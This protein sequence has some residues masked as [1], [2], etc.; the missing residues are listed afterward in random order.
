[1]VPRKKIRRILILSCLAGGNLNL[2]SLGPHSHLH[3]PGTWE[4]C[5]Q[6]CIALAVPL[7]LNGI[8]NAVSRQNLRK[9][10]TPKSL[11]GSLPK[12]YA[13]SFL[14]CLLHV[15]QV[16]GLSNAATRQF[17]QKKGVSATCWCEWGFLELRPL[18]DTSKVSACCGSTKRPRIKVVACWKY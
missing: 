11:R 6:M 8:P 5:S 16:K 12:K 4:K 2:S 14:V 13:K 18:S 10:S 1:M 7:V 17:R 3:V 9:K 15:G